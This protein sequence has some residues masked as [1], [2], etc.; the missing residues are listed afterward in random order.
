VAMK[1]RAVIT[2]FSDGKKQ[3]FPSANKDLMENG[4]SPPAA[5]GGGFNWSMQHTRRCLRSPLSTNLR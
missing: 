3:A 5:K 1:G 4:R 2:S